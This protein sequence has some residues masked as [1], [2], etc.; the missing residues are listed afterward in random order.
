MSANAFIYHF[1]SEAFI[2]VAVVTMVGL[3]V[4]AVVFLPI[5]AF[6]LVPRDERAKVLLT[7]LSLS[8]LGVVAGELGGGSRAAAVGDI[9]P[10][11]L[12]VV[13]GLAVYLFGID[14]TK[15]TIA[16]IAMLAFAFGLFWGY[17]GGSHGRTGMD[18]NG[19]VEAA[20]LDLFFDAALYSKEGPYSQADQGP[21]DMTRLEEVCNKFLQAVAP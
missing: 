6:G 5:A 9:I 20:C 15:G 4:A 12:G 11:V 7:L 3:L 2:T 18:S 8:I 14:R 1:N 13:G 17:V 10:S 16:S 21:L 19:R